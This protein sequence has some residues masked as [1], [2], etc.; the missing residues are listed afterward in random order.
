[1]SSNVVAGNRMDHAA[2]ALPTLARAP[3]AKETVVTVRALGSIAAPALAASGGVLRPIEGFTDSPYRL[4]GDTIV[5]LGTRPRVLHPRMVVVDSAPPAAAPVR[6][7]VGVIAAPWHPALPMVLDETRFR[8]RT[9]CLA[10][11]AAQI[12]A[13]RG[14][15]ALLVGGVPPFPLDLGVPRVRAL[16]EAV[17]AEDE[18]AILEAATRLL[19]FGTGLTPSG[20]DLVGGLLFALRLRDPAGR[21][22]Q[23]LAA[24]LVEAARSRTHAISA[25]LFADLA[26]GASYA[27]LHDLVAALAGDASPDAVVAT[28]RSLAGVGHSSGWDMLTGFVLGT[29]G[30]LE[31]GTLEHMAARRLAATPRTLQ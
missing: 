19:G 10:A 1:M 2:G 29:T 16:G 22:H 12:D 31:P 30:T 15:G 18:H 6:A 21:A 3:R 27:W 26:A 11:N 5:W 24:R 8:R 28:A 17:A 25:A 7:A 4:A 20:D 23:A 13:P 14:F 9:A